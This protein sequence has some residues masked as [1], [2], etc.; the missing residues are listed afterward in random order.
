MRS[1]LTALQRAHFSGPAIFRLIYTTTWPK[2]PHFWYP[3]VIIIYFPGTPPFFLNLLRYHGPSTNL[4]FYLGSLFLHC[5]I[6]MDISTFLFFF[7]LFPY[8]QEHHHI[9][10]QAYSMDLYLFLTFGDILWWRGPCSLLVLIILWSLSPDTLP[11]IHSP[12][13]HGIPS[14]T[15]P[16]SPLTIYTWPCILSC[17][18]FFSSCFFYT[19]T[20]HL[21]L[22]ALPHHTLS[23]LVSTQYFMQSICLIE[24]LFVWWHL[25]P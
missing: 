17:F 23:S 18:P 3:W 19:P 20:R 9:I 24:N 22:I 16:S 7:L 2:Q 13:F 11:C 1:L 6:L 10:P 5:L 4:I 25:R 14:D 21:L 12:L 15:L 8:C